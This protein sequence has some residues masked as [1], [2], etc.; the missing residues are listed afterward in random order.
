MTG[1]KN[2]ILRF[3]QK[4]KLNLLIV[5]PNVVCATKQIYERNKKIS[6]TKK[7]FFFRAKNKKKLIYFLKKGNNDLEKIVTRIY[8]KVGEIIELI[9]SQNGCYFSRITG[10]GSACIGIFSNMKNAIY[11]Q[12]LIKL[13]YPKYWSA[14]SKTI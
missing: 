14:V 8:P 5:Y 6:L 11:A 1:K 3:N 4:Y 2:Q 10:S 13:K 9:K 12:K 7:K